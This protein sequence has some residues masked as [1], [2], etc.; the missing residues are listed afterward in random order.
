[1]LDFDAKPKMPVVPGSALPEE[2][3]GILRNAMKDFLGGFSQPATIDVR[4]VLGQI[5]Q[6]DEQV[7]DMQLALCELY[8]GLHAGD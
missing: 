1:M 8:E 7:T 6:L 2:T 5:E 3:K 4:E